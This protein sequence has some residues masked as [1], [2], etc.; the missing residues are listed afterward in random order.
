MYVDSNNYFKKLLFLAFIIF[1]SQGS[2][3]ENVSPDCCSYAVKKDAIKIQFFLEACSVPGETKF[4][5]VPYFDCQSF[6]LG[7]VSAYR[8]VNSQLP[9]PNQLCI[10]ES[11]TTKNL[12]ELILKQY[13]NWNIKEERLAS[14]VIL[15]ALKSNY[16]CSKI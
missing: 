10:P 13:P 16:S 6:V 1:L 14:E 11:L 9:K 5:M 8:Q 4:G 7:V 2:K 15:E 12:L 3:A